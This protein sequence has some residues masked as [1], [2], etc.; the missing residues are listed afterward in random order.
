M[1]YDDGAPNGRQ[2]SSGQDFQHQNT[3][4]DLRESLL[5]GR[6]DLAKTFGPR[7]LFDY[8]YAVLHSPGYRSCYAEFLKSDFPRIPTP[9]DHSTFAA[10]VPLGRKLVALHLLNP[11]EMPLLG[12]PDVQFAGTGQA[13]VERGYP[14]YRNGRVMINPTRWFEDVPLETWEHHVGGYQ[15]CEKWLKDRAAKGGN[16]PSTGR[17]L[18]HEDILHYRRIVTALTET[19][20]LMAEVDLVIEEHGGWPGAFEVPPPPPPSV[21][22]IIKADESLELEFKSTFQWDLKEGKQNKDLQKSVLKTL[23][24]F[25]NTKGGTLVIGV[26]DNKEIHGLADDLTLT[27]NSLDLFEQAVLAAFSHHIGAP[28]VRHLSLR[29]ADAPG[30]K[31]VCVIVAAPSPEP[32]FLDFQNKNEFY[33][34]RGNASISLNPSE[35]NTYVRQHFKAN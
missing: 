10:L 31:K 19:R 12:S 28:H 7:D 5:G 13:Q 14:E 34:R 33:I 21:E 18:T 23:A 17:V 32:I 1:T 35:Q 16:N 3:E 26:T 6:G 2:E 30:G 8:I 29:F 27:R 4:L 15:V 20:R 9:S 24:A 22:E 11:E 25:M